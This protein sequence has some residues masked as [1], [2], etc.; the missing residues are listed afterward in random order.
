MKG[1]LKEIKKERE[2]EKNQRLDANLLRLNCWYIYPSRR[3]ASTTAGR[4][5][6]AENVQQHIATRMNVFLHLCLL[7][8]NCAFISETLDDWSLC[9]SR[10]STD[11]TFPNSLF[12]VLASCKMKLHP[13][14]EVR[15]HLTELEHATDVP[16]WWLEN[17]VEGWEWTVKKKREISVQRKRNG[18][19]VRCKREIASSRSLSRNYYF[20]YIFSSFIIFVVVL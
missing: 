3:R 8:S 19:V 4:Q 7:L 17:T 11:S 20:F 13:A 5:Q 6:K 9:S 12:R 18:R 14:R 15:N 2:K 10:W 1:E 16:M